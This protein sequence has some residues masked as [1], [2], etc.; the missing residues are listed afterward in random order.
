LNANTEQNQNVKMRTG[1]LHSS[2][3]CLKSAARTLL[4]GHNGQL[5][6]ERCFGN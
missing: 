2:Q 5:D 3:L 6:A 4:G 1:S